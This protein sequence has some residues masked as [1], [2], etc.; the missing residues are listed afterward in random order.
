MTN[1]FY[2]VA[3][4]SQMPILLAV[5]VNNLMRLDLGKLNCFDNND[6]WKCLA[7]IFDWLMKGY[8]KCRRFNVE[9]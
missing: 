4:L 3:L 9:T 6:L 7:N 8:V 5:D 1:K 2:A